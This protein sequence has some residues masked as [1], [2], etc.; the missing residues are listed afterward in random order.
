MAMV[1]MVSM[2]GMVGMVESSGMGTAAMVLVLVVF[3]PPRALLPLLAASRLR[4]N[5][6]APE[7][8][9]ALVLA[10]RASA[11]ASAPAG[12][13]TTTASWSGAHF[14]AKDKYEDR[15]STRLNSSH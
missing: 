15:K 13:L 2:V 4:S 1:P 9:L 10:L 8:A 12:A 7:L 5:L 14:M 11:V 6:E 3:S